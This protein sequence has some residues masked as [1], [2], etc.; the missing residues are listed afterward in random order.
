M[1]APLLPAD[2]PSDDTPAEAVDAFIQKW[3][4]GQAAEIANAQGFLLD[5]CDLLGVPKPDPATKDP[6]RDAY[7]FE[8]PVLFQDG[9][10]TSTGRIDLYKRGCFVLETKQGV[11]EERKQRGRTRSTGHGTRGSAAWERAIKAA[12]EQAARY[13]RNLDHPGAPPEPVPPLVIVCDVGYCFDLYANFGHPQRYSAFPDPRAFRLLLDDLRRPEARATL[14]LAFADPHALDPS[15]RQAQV[16][17]KLAAT[18]AA[19]AADFEAQGHPPD[20]VFGF[21]TRCLFTMFAEDT[22]LLPDGSFTHLLRDYRDHLDVLPDALEALWTTMDTGGFS[23][24]LKARVR[25]F[26]GSLF[27]RRPIPSE[28]PDSG[29]PPRPAGTPPGQEG[30]SGGASNEAVPR[31]NRSSP[32]GQ[33]E[34][35]AGGRG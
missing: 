21:L 28:A 4:R 7:V 2:L 18:L 5:L 32:L 34:Y 11:D 30:S 23:P 6:A 25:R 12:K 35:P 19:L 10:T 9:A 17:R 31:E 24:A 14:R 22:A 1:P 8:R 33:G 16:T 27:S 3:Q 20:A 26:N 29:P 13:A 15:R